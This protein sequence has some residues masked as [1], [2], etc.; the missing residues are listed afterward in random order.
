M[1]HFLIVHVYEP[2]GDV[3]ELLEKS[4]VEGVVGSGSEPSQVRTNRRPGG[5]GRTC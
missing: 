2:P 1:C 4:S 3:F 5:T